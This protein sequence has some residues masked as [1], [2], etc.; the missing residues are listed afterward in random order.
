MGEWG[1][2]IAGCVAAVAAFVGIALGANAW[3]RSNHEASC[4]AFSHETGRETRFVKYTTW[5]W[6]CLTPGSD[7]KWISVDNLRD[8]VK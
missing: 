8:G 7:G 3:D 1:L 4:V 5:S 2:F 6:D